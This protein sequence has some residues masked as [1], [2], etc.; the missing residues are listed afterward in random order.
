MFYSRFA[1]QC[2]SHFKHTLGLATL[3][4]S[5]VAMAVPSGTIVHPRNNTTYTN[6]LTLFFNASD[7]ATLNTVGLTFGDVN[8]GNQVTFCDG[9][10]NSRY[11]G[12]RTG[13]R[14]IDFGLNP[15]QNTVH[16]WAN[17]PDNILS[18]TT[19]T[20]QP[21]EITPVSAQRTLTDIN[22]NWSSLSGY[23]R[24]NAYIATE[25]GVTPSNF[26]SLENGQVFR[27]LR[28]TEFTIDNADPQTSYYVRITGVDGTGESAFSAEEV[29][30]ALNNTLPEATDDQFTLNEDTSFSSNLLS[31]DN[32]PDNNDPTTPTQTLTASVISSPVNGSV[33]LSENGDFTYTPNSNFNGNDSFTYQI[34]DDFQGLAQA[35]VTLQVNPVNDN[36]IANTDTFTVNEDTILTQPANSLTSNDSDI[37]G[38]TVSVSTLP[39]QAPG[40]GVVVINSNG[41]FTYTPNS[42]FNGADSFVYTLQDGQGGTDT[43]LVQ[44]TVLAVADAP[45]V[46]N[47]TAEVV[48]GS[49]VIINVL[50]NDQNPDGEQNLLT[51]ISAQANNGS[52]VINGGVSLTYT[53]N[54]GFSGTDTITYEVQQNGTGLSTS[55]SVEITVA[56]QPQPPVAADDTAST[57]EDTTVTIN[58]LTNDT[59]PEGQTLTV[60]LASSNTG[61]VSISANS[62]L[63]FT[64][65]PDFN[66]QANISYTVSD[67]GG[68]TASATVAVNVIA[69]NDDPVAE[70]DSFELNEDTT[71]NVAAPALLSNDS[72]PDNDILTVSATVQ[73]PAF[74]ALQLGSDGSFTYTPN[75][76]FNGNDSFSY[77]ISDGNG[78]E[79]T[80]TVN[81]TVLPVAD[82]PETTDDTFSVEA[83]VPIEMDVLANDNNIDPDQGS[84]VIVS[85]TAVNGSVSIL[86]STLLSYQANIDFEGTDTITYTA[87]VDN[88]ASNPT[89]TGNVTVEVTLPN[90]P[91]VANADNASVDEDASVVISPLSNDTDPENDTISLVSATADSGSVEV[92]GNTLV[93]SPSE[94]FNG[95]VSIS[96]TIEDSEQNSASGTISVNVA[97]VNDNPVTTPD[98]GTTLEDT[99]LTI[100]VV[101][102]DTDIDGD[103]VSLVSAI[104]SQGDIQILNVNE[105]RYTPR[106]DFNGA[107]S[108]SY[109]VT[110]NNGGEATGNVAVTITPVNDAPRPQDDEFTVDDGITVTLTP[111]QNDSDPEGDILSIT[112]ATA[113]YGSVS[114]AN[115]SLLVYTPPASFTHSDTINYTVVDSVGASASAQITIAPSNAPPQVSDDTY[116]VNDLGES[117]VIN[118]HVGVLIN[119]SDPE[120]LTL[121]TTISTSPQFASSFNLF[122]D[123]SF[124]YLHDGSQNLVDS[125]TY[126]ASDG[127]TTTTGTVSIDVRRYNDIPELCTIPSVN[128]TEGESYYFQATVFDNDAS[129]VSYSADNLPAWLD[130]N[131]ETGVLSG[132]PPTGSDNAS[133]ITLTV[134]DGVAETDLITFDIN[135]QEAFGSNNELALDLGGAK[136]R[137]NAMKRDNAGRIVAVGER[138]DA[139][140][141]VRL[142][143]N[144]ELDSSFDDDGVVT[145]PF[146]GEAWAD[147]L[148]IDKNNA[149]VVI[150]QT[151][152]AT[153]GDAEIGIVRIT[154]SGALDTSFSDDGTLEIDIAS[155]TADY[156]S[157][158]VLHNNGD[159][160][161]A[162]Y[163][164]NDG[165]KDIV[166]IQVENDGTLDSSFSSD[167]ILAFAFAND[168]IAEQM[169]HD[170]NHHLLLVGSH[171]NGTDSDIVLAQVDLDVNGDGI[172]DGA[173]DTGFGTGG[174]KIINLGSDELATDFI[175]NSFG[176]WIVAGGSNGKFGVFSFDNTGALNTSSFN[177]NSGY[178]EHDFSGMSGEFAHAI[179]DDGTGSFFAF[180]KVG[181][182]IGV[183]K[184]TASGTLDGAFASSGEF[185]TTFISGSIPRLSHD[186]TNIGNVPRL[187]PS[188][189]P[190]TISGLANEDARIAAIR[191]AGGQ[192]LFSGSDTFTNQLL[193]F[194]K[195]ESQ[196]VTYST[197]DIGLAF[198]NHGGS[199]TKSEDKIIDVLEATAGEFY[200]V[201]YSPLFVGAN[202]DLVVTK[203]N[204]QSVDI[205]KY[206]QNGIAR[207][208]FDGHFST[209]AAVV[210]SAYDVIAA[211]EYNANYI[212]VAKVNASGELDSS[213][214]SSGVQDFGGAEE[215]PPF[216][217]VIDSSDNVIIGTSTIANSNLKLFK[218]TATGSRD[219]AFGSN[220]EINYSTFELPHDI[221]LTSTGGLY[222][223]GEDYTGGTPAIM[224]LNADGSPDTNFSING[225]LSID[226]TTLGPITVLSDD[227]VIAVTEDYDGIVVRKYDS[228]GSL[229]TSFGNEGL[230]LNS[231]STLGTGST[232]Y[233]DS[234]NNVFVMVVDEDSHHVLLKIDPDG[235]S[236]RSFVNAGEATLS[237]AIRDWGFIRGF[238]L[239]S[240]GQ[241]VIYGEDNFDFALA[242]MDSDGTIIHDEG[243]FY[244]DFGTGEH[245]Y[246]IAIAPNRKLYIAGSSS[247]PLTDVSSLAL[248]R[249]ATDGAADFAFNASDGVHVEENTY[250]QALSSISI[251][252]RGQVVV[253]GTDDNSSVSGRYKAGLTAIDDSFN[254]GEP[255]VAT[256]SN[257]DT[258]NAHVV[259]DLGVIWQAGQKG[260]TG[261]VF[262]ILSSGS[263]DTAFATIS[264]EINSDL[265]AMSDSELL[266]ITQTS[267]GEFV[268]LGTTKSS[269]LYNSFMVKFD[270]QGTINT[271]FGTNGFVTISDEDYSIVLSDIALDAEGNFVAVGQAN[272]QAFA[273][274]IDASGNNELNREF[275]SDTT[276]EQASALAI[277][278]Y[279]AIFVA[280]H[281]SGG[282]N[283]YRLKPDLST[284]NQY[285]S[286]RFGELFK[287]R[288]VAVDDIGN[289]YVTGSAQFES[290]WDIFTLKYPG[291]SGQFDD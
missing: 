255:S 240:T 157:A 122:S 145:V 196:D 103:R 247:E 153:N 69:V 56:P 275:L 155:N 86:G 35:Q 141:V 243:E 189:A 46:N 169:R 12:F 236:D 167:G 20:W 138:D 82:A 194:R 47:D 27:S 234:N 180:G 114:V 286:R 41:G 142:L 156:P 17:S 57:N 237:N 7:T 149:I 88:N 85:A 101:Q 170:G 252:A 211:A 208:A 74:G 147:D 26:S 21:R 241:F 246:G 227:S 284:I 242:H 111:L 165:D 32:D 217:M 253:S 179:V 71:L 19:F 144:G 134:N 55:G 151:V 160:S 96:Y 285:P 132:T 223:A 209:Q 269:E 116:I 76:N 287:S 92:S 239:E 174:M 37:D 158:V 276:F 53:A 100:N 9:N 207:I 70:A 13:V 80:G 288:D 273:V 213:F 127:V 139:F 162:G 137:I 181:N 128:I 218:L 90:Q 43:G 14:P 11:R 126:E 235:Q 58:V 266:S 65:E 191:D 133:N 221:E 112:S 199:T 150:G 36:P 95:S 77:A 152:D 89:T 135:V 4:V 140:L 66:G 279:G 72:D 119:D 171:H 175:L 154:D 212:R 232:I 231:H 226:T 260:N 40:S 164:V 198:R 121:T 84:L 238:S 97:P 280:T 45:I 73:A 259:D 83:G 51:I 49:D 214:A 68:L 161:V 28:N 274:R 87:Q 30:P 1:L 204:P 102:N 182:D 81:L 184:L 63:L 48:S 173:W 31:N 39:A 22:V 233:S 202:N 124:F 281:S 197:C 190:T 262:K 178:L 54:N 131:G 5:C 290:E 251:N 94:N 244:L 93:Y 264:G 257:T 225:L 187:A 98:S 216:D 91:P 115:A 42:N 120:G 110:D 23:L 8:T 249:M 220:G 228:S 148:A 168:Q 130:L 263:E 222:V 15:G 118:T 18:T 195:A 270:R 107:D 136:T 108:I 185:T 277:D 99:S 113:S 104:A 271:Q 215:S 254:A 106:G 67:P 143:S 146:A 109:S 172:E 6:N 278:K 291:A 206:G 29:V 176:D 25:P 289:V 267:D 205:D 125:F 201:G 62:S 192:L 79:A 129:S 10:C 224:K 60:T 159:I 250:E 123:G 61:T 3:L 200:A 186:N 183:V 75:E 166:V 282:F 163:F 50:D 272:D 24:Y 203:I 44:I 105:L 245:S 64:P 34:E 210:T 229:V 258:I 268:A 2:I 248:T 177:A 33:T 230:F 38:N 283:L 265:S 193:F 188:A 256:D 117:I 78:G 59:D 16:L 261:Y 52:V 219:S